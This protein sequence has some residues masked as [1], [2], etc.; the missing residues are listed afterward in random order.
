MT[1][2]DNHPLPGGGTVRVLADIVIETVDGRCLALCQRCGAE[3][4]RWTSGEQAPPLRC[5]CPSAARAGGD[6]S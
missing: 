1:S 3:L 4:G 6:G 5:P 2:S